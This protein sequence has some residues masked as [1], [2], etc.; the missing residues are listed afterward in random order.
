MGDWRGPLKGKEE[1]RAYL[2]A[3]DQSDTGIH[4]VQNILI[5]VEDGQNANGSAVFTFHGTRRDDPGALTPRVVGRYRDRFVLTAQGWRFARRETD[6][7][8]TGR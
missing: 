6:M 3:K 1:I 7:V 5:D 8:F 4:I 2:D